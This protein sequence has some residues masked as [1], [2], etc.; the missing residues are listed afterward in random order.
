MLTQAPVQKRIGSKKMDRK[1]WLTTVY[2]EANIFIER[3]SPNEGELSPSEIDEL[4]PELHQQIKELLGSIDN[5]ED[6]IKYSLLKHPPA[7]LWLGEN[8]WQHVVI[9]VAGAC[10]MHDVKGVV[11]KILDGSLPKTPSATLLEPL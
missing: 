6:L 9:A 10:L 7:D 8:N 5:P 3:N 2:R 4:E 11:L 1:Q